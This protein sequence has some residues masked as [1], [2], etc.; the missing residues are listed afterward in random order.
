MPI[1]DWLLH[2][3]LRNSRN[4]LELSVLENAVISSQ[5][6]IN[7]NKLKLN[8]ISSIK[9]SKNQNRISTKITTN[10]TTNK[11]KITFELA[12]MS[13]VQSAAIKLTF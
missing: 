4:G 7:F 13:T 8:F 3:K 9:T 6:N 1:A 11:M 5:N 2:V 10:K 12:I